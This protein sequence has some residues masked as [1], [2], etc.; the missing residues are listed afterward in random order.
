LGL[1]CVV[2]V[3]MV[4]VGIIIPSYNSARFLPQTIESVRAQTV[5]N[6]KCLI[7][8]DCSTDNSLQIADS[9]CAGDARFSVLAL[10]KNL[11]VSG[12]R[13]AGIAALG[14][15]VQYI[16]FLDSDDM[17]HPSALQLLVDAIERNPS[18]VAVYG[19]CRLVDQDGKYVGSE[20][21]ETASRE[22]FDYRDGRL[23]PLVNAT[24]INFLQ[25]V[26]RCPVVS[27]GAMLIRSDIIAKITDNTSVLFDMQRNLAEDLDAWFRLRRAG[28]IGHVDET[29]LDY[30]RHGANTSSRGW[31]MAINTR[32][33]RLKALSD[34]A[35][36]DGEFHEA[37][38]AFRAY[39]RYRIG[40]ELRSAAACLGSG[41]ISASRRLIGCTFVSAVDILVVRLFQL[42]RS[43][44]M[45]SFDKRRTA[46]RGDVVAAT[47]ASD[48]VSG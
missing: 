46:Q 23:V 12:A 26:C 11:G 35:I 17:W 22:T 9:L 16:C 39:R 40:K 19:N 47:D 27:P 20:K 31:H 2:P 37:C 18:W 34:P 24:E 1:I 41:Q 28:E 14:Q 13:N 5:F 30:R 43:A 15:S 42:S 48:P 29:V 8:D 6:F 3:A 45:L 33:V 4:D 44:R 7:V 38:G 21:I 36:S 10:P 32:Q 25:F